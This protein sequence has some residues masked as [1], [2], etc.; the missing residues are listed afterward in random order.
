LRGRLLAP[1]E[2]RPSPPGSAETRLGVGRYPDLRY[3]S[4]TT[5]TPENFWKRAKK[6]DSCWIWIG[7]KNGHG[8]GQV[9]VFPSRKR[10]QAP[11]LAWEFANGRPVDKGKFVCHSC[12][13]PACVNPDHLWLGTHEQNMDDRAAKGRNSRVS[14]E[15]H[16]QAKLTA[17]AV[18][19]MREM[20][21]RGASWGRLGVEFGVTRQHAK[22]VC[23]GI[24]WRDIYTSSPAG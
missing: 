3:A 5:M 14:G 2:L 18:M 10:I 19:R 16:G 9:R 7:A 8:Y 24:N 6:T 17:S 4:V 21:H 1:L 11:R 13:N 22:R 12:D 23:V 15:N 20:R